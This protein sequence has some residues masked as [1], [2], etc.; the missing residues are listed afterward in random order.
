MCTDETRD[1]RYDWR[2]WNEN[3]VIV[4]QLF[5][6][7]DTNK[8]SMLTFDEFL[9]TDEQYAGMD[10]YSDAKKQEFDMLD[11]NSEWIWW[12]VYTILLQKME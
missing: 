1:R 10:G 4:E 9:H 6:R 8:D 2:K 12:R 7:V 3:I 11:G 5:K